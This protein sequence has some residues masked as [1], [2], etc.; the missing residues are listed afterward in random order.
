VTAAMDD[1][2]AIRQ[3]KGRYFRTMDTKDWDGMRQVFT[4]DLVTDNTASPG[5]TV[6]EG[7]DV[8]MAFLRE[9]LGP[10]TTVHHGHTPEITITS[11][12]T[13]TGI[14]AMEDMLRWPDGSEIHGYGHYHE[15]YEK[16][17]GDWRIKR[18]TLTRLRNDTTAPANA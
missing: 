11:P 2:E 14:W 3:L 6:I 12:T 15:V 13:A 1:Y 18:L 4:D 8:F 16:V 9:V 7:A 17:D 10:V 5:G